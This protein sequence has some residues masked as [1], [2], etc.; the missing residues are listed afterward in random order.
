MSDP[1]EILNTIRIRKAKIGDI[2]S[3]SDIDTRQ[4]PDPWKINHFIDELSHNISFFYVAEEVNS[5]TIMGYINFWIVEETLELHKV[6]V[7]EDFTGKGIGKRLFL[8]M[9]ET[10]KNKNV[11]ELFLE[12]RKSNT[13]AIKLYK[14]FGFQLIDVRKN[15]YSEPQEDA[16]IYKLRLGVTFHQEKVSPDQQ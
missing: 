11:E 7:S 4:F 15:Y 1:K 2:D 6:A 3:I 10:A 14:S 5:K 8:F 16:S 9:L 12:V 13:A